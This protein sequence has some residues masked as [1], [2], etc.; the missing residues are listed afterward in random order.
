MVFP[1]ADKVL[2]DPDQKEL[3]SKFA[4][5]DRTMGFDAIARLERFARGLSPIAAPSSASGPKK[6]KNRQGAR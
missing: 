2:R 4:E 3:G 5:V 1:M 6:V